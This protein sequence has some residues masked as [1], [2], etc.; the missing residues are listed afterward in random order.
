[1]IGCYDIYR[2]HDSVPGALFQARFRKALQRANQFAKRTQVVVE[3]SRFL[4]NRITR[5]ALRIGSHSLGTLL[6]DV[7][8]C[9]RPA[10]ERRQLD[11]RLVNKVQPEQDRVQVD[12]EMVE[13][14]AFNILD[15]A[16]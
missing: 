10:A 1:A 5:E 6:N 11:V 12:Y 15:N 16:I 2:Q 4:L 13:M 3:Q 7:A 8:Q 14:L 9:L